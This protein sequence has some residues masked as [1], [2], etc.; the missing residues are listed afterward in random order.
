LTFKQKRPVNQF[1]TKQQVA[2]PGLFF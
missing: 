1:I 2:P